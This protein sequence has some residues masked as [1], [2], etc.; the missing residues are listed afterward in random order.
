M[1]GLTSAW[2]LQA[3]EDNKKGKLISIDLPMRDWKKYMGS[4][5]MGPGSE[6]E[7]D[8]LSDQDPGWIVPNYLKPRWELILGPSEI[9]LK[10]ICDKKGK[11][12]LFVHD[13]D[14]SYENMKFE[15]EYI[16][17]NFPKANIVID[18]FYHNHYT[19]ELLAEDQY[20]GVLIDDLDSYGNIFPSTAFLK[21]K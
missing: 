4:R 7:E 16:K 8:E 19:Y 13:S 14:H 10:D 6:V 11:V 1:H 21:K 2:I 15:C 17:D 5:P 20:E 18:D 3:L 9:H 12:D